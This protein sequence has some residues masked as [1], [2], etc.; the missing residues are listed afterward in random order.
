MGTVGHSLSDIHRLLLHE[1]ACRPLTTQASQRHDKHDKHN[2]HNTVHHTTEYSHL[3]VAAAGCQGIVDIC[4]EV[5]STKLQEEIEDDEGI[6]RVFVTA[7][8]PRTRTETCRNVT[9]NGS[10]DSYP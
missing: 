4:D 6:W 7:S 9:E 8:Q 2:K 5:C 1:S 10:E 3:R